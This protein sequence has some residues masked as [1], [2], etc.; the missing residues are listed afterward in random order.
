MTKTQDSSRQERL[1]AFW[2]RMALNYP[3]PF[4]DKTL[5][6]TRQVLS[7]VKGMGVDFSNA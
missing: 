1:N 5:A 4:D 7:L 6:G 3:L 2:E